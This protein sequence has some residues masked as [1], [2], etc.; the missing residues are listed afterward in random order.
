MASNWY[1]R[2]IAECNKHVGQRVRVK[3]N[4]ELSKYIRYDIKGRYGTII[5]WY[6]NYNVAVQLDDLS[7][8]GSQYGYFYLE[9]NELEIIENENMEETT[10]AINNNSITNYLNTAKVVKSDGRVY[11]YANYIPDLKEGDRC[12][13]VSDNRDMSVA[14]VVEIIFE[15]SEPMSREVVCKIDTWAY[16]DRVETRKKAAELKQKMQERAKKLQDIVLYQT[17]AKEDAEMAQLLA[18]FTNLDSV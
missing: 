3:H 6:G 1:K 16:D 11:N 10:M 5:H 14:E 2:L 15:N 9:K 4:S 12:V 13:V 7:N 8:P 18:D 17:L